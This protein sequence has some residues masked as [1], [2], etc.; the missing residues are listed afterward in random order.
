MTPIK[1]VIARKWGKSSGH[2]FATV[3]PEDTEKL[4]AALNGK[5]LDSRNLMYSFFLFFFS[6]LSLSFSFF[7]NHCF[8]LCTYYEFNC[9]CVCVCVCVWA[10]KS[11]V[12]NLKC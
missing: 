1:V 6:F 5:E 11:F 10:V 8:D 4:I 9:V 7:F 12:N 3:N 2:G